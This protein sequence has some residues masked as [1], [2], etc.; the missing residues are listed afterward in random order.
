MTFRRKLYDELL[1]WK[2]CGGKRALLVEGARGVGKSTIVK[3]FAEKEYDSYILID[4]SIAG[5]NV[6]DCFKYNM[7]NLDNLFLILSSAYKTTLYPRKS[8]I[9][10]DEVQAFPRARQ[11]VKYLVADGRYDYI[12]TGSLISIRQN[13]K[14]ILIPSEERSV[15]MYPMD[16]EEFCWALGEN[17]LIS[18]IRKCYDK[19]VPLEDGLHM[20]AMLLFEEYMLVG[21]MPRCVSAF[22]DNARSLEAADMEKRKLLCL[23]EHDINMA[24]VSD[25][26]KIRGIYRRLP[27][28]LA[29]STKRVVYREICIGSYFEDFD[30]AFFWL[31]DSMI[32]NICPN[33][34]E[35]DGRLCVNED[36]TLIKCYMGDTG[37][38]LSLAYD[39]PD[40]LLKDDL[41]NQILQGNFSVNN[42]MLFE[43]AIAQ[44][45]VSS[46][47]RLYFYTHYDVV[48]HR[49]D[50]EID[51]MLTYG[52]KINFSFVPIAVK[53]SPKYKIDSLNRFAENHVDSISSLVVILPLNF[54]TDGDVLYI[55]PYMTFC[56]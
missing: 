50:T 48:G 30:G 28:F 13:V 33:C 6:R 14:D 17:L 11:C 54:R 4:F 44:M 39:S 1:D 22:M 43:N 51:F 55:P 46:G 29:S 25:R 45:L 10:F 49:Y 42:G 3:E 15:K 7:N 32:C 40:S 36:R 35:P 12:E 8:L 23:Y 52:D 34:G 20:R 24:P 21:G 47:H 41:Y 53:S 26:G 56:L 38:L 27:A 2:K 16:F 37:L 31:G 9:I 5:D 19:R 18:Y